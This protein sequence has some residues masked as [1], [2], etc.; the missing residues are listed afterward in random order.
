MRIAI[1]SDIHG[2]LA[3]LEAVTEDLRHRAVDAVVNLGDGLSGP[4]LPLETA[5]F[6]MARNWTQLSG[7]HE[8][9][10]L[11]LAGDRSPC[12]TTTRPW[13]NWPSCADARTGW[14]PC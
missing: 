1:L 3:A 10:V 12:L 8:R 4:L 9:Q 14:T 5:Q 7:H 2:N 6:L 13:R 11:T